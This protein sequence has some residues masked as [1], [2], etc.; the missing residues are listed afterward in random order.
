MDRVLS[1]VELLE[2]ILL[3]IND[4]RSILTAV[5]RVCRLWN[6]IVRD[7]PRMQ[8]V[9]FFRPDTSLINDENSWAQIRMNPLLL[10]Y[11]DGVLTRPTNGKVQSVALPIQD[12]SQAVKASWHRMLM[13]QPPARTLG[14]WDIKTGIAFEHGFDITSQMLEMK[15]GEGVSMDMLFERINQ[16]GPGSPWTLFWGHEGR[17]RLEKE[18]NSLFVRKTSASKRA[19]LFNMWQEADVI[20]K[21]GC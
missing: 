15:D 8:Q 17:E 13:Q 2:L 14:V 11:F 1:T 7:S 4:I 10:C 16:L 5:I 6:H 19:T 18:K 9:L 3:E 21:F 12:D 20:V